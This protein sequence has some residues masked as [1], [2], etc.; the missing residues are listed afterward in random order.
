MEIRDWKDKNNVSSIV[1]SGK[2]LKVL[3]SHVKSGSLLDIG[4]GKGK[5]LKHASQN[6]FDVLGFD[7]KNYTTD[8]MEVVEGDASKE[9]PD[10]GKKFKI[11]TAWNVAEHL[12]N[13]WLFF[14]EVNKILDSNGIFIF[15]IPN[16]FEFKNK[17]S[18]LFRGEFYRYNDGNDHRYPFTEHLLK[19]LI[20][21][22]SLLERGYYSGSR[23]FAKTEYFVLQKK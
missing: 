14:R 22:F 9:L 16:V 4:C 5:F 10:F 15:S 7:F 13:P 20:A 12:E 2:A 21:E 6:G 11:V 1:K 23:L 18:F 8:L 17:L 19:E 3:L